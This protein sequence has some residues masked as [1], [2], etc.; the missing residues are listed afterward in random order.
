MPV[1]ELIKLLGDEEVKKI[2]NVVII[3]AEN[4]EYQDSM[5]QT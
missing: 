5:K 4:F 3:T 2:C 1:S